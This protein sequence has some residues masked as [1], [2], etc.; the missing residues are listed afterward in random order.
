MA[1]REAL[2]K[3]EFRDWY[4]GIVPGIWYRAAW[5]AAEVLEQQ[6]C[7]EPRWA[8]GDRLLTDAHFL[9]RGGRNRPAQG[10]RTRWGELQPGR[11]RDSE[12]TLAIQP[13]A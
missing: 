5:L 8:L 9:F 4:P 7:G 3:P 12:H 2:L 1:A 6:R 13:P 10:R 11:P